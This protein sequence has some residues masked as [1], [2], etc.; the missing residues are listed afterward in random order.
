MIDQLK[1]QTELAFG[2]NIKSQK[3]CNSLSIQILATTG[4]VVS[5]S[6]IRR[7]WGL[8]KANTKPSLTTL[9]VLC[10]Y[11]NYKDWDDFVK[12]NTEQTHTEL[13]Q[14]KQWKTAQKRCNEETLETLDFIKGRCGIQYMFAID[15]RLAADRL[16]TFLRS[17]YTATAI[18]GPGGY[19]KS[20]LLAKWVERQM[21]KNSDNDTLLLFIRGKKLESSI[22]TGSLF[23]RWINHKLSGDNTA[24]IKELIGQDK[25]HSVVIV[26]DGLD[27]INL[28]E[29]KIIDISS[30]IAEY[31]STNKH[32]RFKLIVSS[33]NSTWERNFLP[34]IFH[35]NPYKTDWL[36]SWTSTNGKTFTNIPPLSRIE[37]QDI[38]NKTI[39]SGKPKK[40]LVDDLEI[41]L[42]QAISYPF[43]LQLF[44]NTGGEGN[45]GTSIGNLDLMDL[46][47]KSQIYNSPLADEKLDLIYAILDSQKFGLSENITLKSEIKKKYPLHLKTVGKYYDAYQDLLSYGIISE[48]VIES[49]FKILKTVIKIANDNLRCSLIVR[50]LVESND[51]IDFSLFKRVDDEY[52]DGETKVMII[53]NLYHEAYLSRNIEALL[54]FFTLKTE[55][56]RKAI[57]QSQLGISIH[58]DQFMG[59][60]LIS[61]YAKNP[62]AQ[63][64]LFENVIDIDF[65]TTS[66]AHMMQEYLK[67]KKDKESIIFANTMLALSHIYKLERSK[68][69]YYINEIK[70]TN[71]NLTMRPSTIARWLGV[72]LLYSFLTSES[73]D[74][75][76]I[77]SLHKF[78]S[79]IKKEEV[80]SG[81]QGRA[82]FESIIAFMLICCK[83]Y[84]LAG[85]IIEKNTS[86]LQAFNHNN[87][88]LIAER[89]VLQAF[90]RWGNQKSIEEETIF[91]IEESME[92]INE[93]NISNIKSLAYAMIGGFYFNQHKIQKFNTYFQTALELVTHYQNKFSEI[94][95]LR[96]L[97]TL[98]RQLNETNS[99]NQCEIYAKG[100]AENSGFLFSKF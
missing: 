69:Y 1:A 70:K 7:C 28:P 71:P 89:I 36:G 32:N 3:D 19:G 57:T 34:K 68:A 37:I 90:A 62:T 87:E 65:L 88:G 48:E 59:N 54:P 43:Y 97:S 17:T 8:L 49:K 12:K 100:M 80:L 23:K 27:E 31:V 11:C 86:Q 82:E 35:E 58:K 72:Q 79:A 30:Q 99:A 77:K 95:L 73:I 51:G 38:L 93:A 25:E 67:Y 14:S 6:T 44:I 9:N 64:L 13:N 24:G 94:K 91:A 66:Y 47:L 5:H 40:L 33:R 4:E 78:H 22:G 61:E 45:L 29:N 46:F 26:I 75:E 42:R 84:S 63:T 41:N 98:L 92:S 2:R 96:L 81:K 83:E 21:A 85:K 15:R 74:Q 76:L 16:D 18:V 20:T 55:T 52:P 50:H 56:L 60:K 39:N 10:K 53:A